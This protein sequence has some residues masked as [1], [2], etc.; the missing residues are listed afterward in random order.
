[1]RSSCNFSQLKFWKRQSNIYSGLDAV[2]NEVVIIQDVDLEY[3]PQ[4]I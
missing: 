2:K 4:N 3:Y 1:M